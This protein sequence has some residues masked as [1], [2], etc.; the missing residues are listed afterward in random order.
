[1]K[2]LFIVPNNDAE[3]I[4]IQKLIKENNNGEYEIILTGQGWRCFL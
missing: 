2:K 4:Q 1:M 3:A